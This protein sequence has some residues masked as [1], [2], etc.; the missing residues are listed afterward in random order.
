MEKHNIKFFRQ[1]QQ[2]LNY[3]K[4]HEKKEIKE[5]VS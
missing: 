3:K 4:K 1:N 5:M 2:L